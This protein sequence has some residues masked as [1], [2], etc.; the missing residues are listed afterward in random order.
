MNLTERGIIIRKTAEGDLPQI[1]SSGIEEPAF[2][3]MPFAFNA[4]NLADIFASDN[5]VC[6][7]AVRKKKVLGFIIGSIEDGASRVYWMMVKEKFRKA[8]IGKE[9]LKLYIEFS[10]KHGAADFLIAV[11]QNNHD[12]VKFFTENGFSV[13]EDFIRLQKNNL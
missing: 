12:S 1:Y 10:K 8:G 2:S 7:S 11:F 6:Y 4:E 9:M 5:S 3:D 13:K